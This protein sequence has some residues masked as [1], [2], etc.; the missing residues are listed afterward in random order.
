[1]GSEFLR[2]WAPV[3]ISTSRIAPQLESSNPDWLDHAA[4]IEEKLPLVVVGQDQSLEKLQ[5]EAQRW[6]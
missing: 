6:D 5:V 3:R 2:A 1:M 4:P